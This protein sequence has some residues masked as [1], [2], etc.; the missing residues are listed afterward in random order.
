MVQELPRH[1]AM[2]LNLLGFKVCNSTSAF[3]TKSA[4]CTSGVSHCSRE[5][6]VQFDYA[7]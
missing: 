5:P 3:N 7:L 1:W 6:S 2:I 4:G